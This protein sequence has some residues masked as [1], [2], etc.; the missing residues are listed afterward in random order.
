MPGRQ[1]ERG[2]GHHLKQRGHRHDREPVGVLR[3]AL[4]LRD[5]AVVGELG[6]GEQ[7]ELPG[8]G[9]LVTAAVV[10]VTGGT[11][12]G[13]GPLQG[14][15]SRRADKGLGNRSGGGSRLRHQRAELGQHGCAGRQHG[16]AGRQQGCTSGQ[17]GCTSEKG[18]CTGGQ[19]EWAD[20]SDGL[21]RAGQ[22]DERA[23]Q[24]Q[25]DTPLR[26][27][28]LRV[29]VL[30]VAVLRVVALRVAVPGDAVL[31]DAA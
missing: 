9:D 23:T 16:C 5:D 26:D 17:R 8:R 12:P 24:A 2:V 1:R 11:R 25:P 10:S 20:G 31:G 29:A 3:P 15:T 22:P 28:V 19:R 6:H 14:R 7:R 13:N 18:E 21:H 30:R 4:S 27:T